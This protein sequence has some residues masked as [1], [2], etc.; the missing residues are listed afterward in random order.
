MVPRSIGYLASRAS[1]TEHWVTWPATSSFT[2]PS[3]RASVRRCAGSTT[4]IMT[5]PRSSQGLHLHGQHG[6]QIAD[7][8]LPAVA[9]VGRGVHLPAGGAE[10]DPAGVERV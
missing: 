7:D 3:T 10:V 6:R 9:G 4:R 5:V 2:S 1:S 8:R